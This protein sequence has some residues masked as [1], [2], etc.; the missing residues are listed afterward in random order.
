MATV[1]YL[2]YDVLDDY[3]WDLTDEDLFAKAAEKDLPE[4]DHG[5]FEVSEG[6]YILNA[7]EGEGHQWPFSCRNGICS[8]CAAIL[9]EGEITME[10]NQALNEEEVNEKN[11]RLTCIGIPKSDHV[12]IV[13]NA[14]HLDYLQDRVIY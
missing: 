4:T 7:A 2:N 11:V 10:G 9:K 5:T 13:Y 3:G 1:E 12:K 6:E 8:N 14:K